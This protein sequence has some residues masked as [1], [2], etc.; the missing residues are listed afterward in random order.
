MTLDLPLWLLNSNDA[1]ENSRSTVVCICTTC[2]SGVFM[3]F[4]INVAGTSMAP[5]FR[6]TF[7]SGLNSLYAY[8]TRVNAMSACREDGHNGVLLTRC[9]ETTGK[10]SGSA[11]SVSAMTVTLF[12]PSNFSDRILCTDVVK[13]L[14][15]GGSTMALGAAAASPLVRVQ[16]PVYWSQ[17]TFSS[18]P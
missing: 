6:A 2:D 1:R 7:P 3:F 14:G 13:F 16:S 11:R 8:S 5:M 4:K 9:P 18:N 15:F 12:L 17:Y 10:S